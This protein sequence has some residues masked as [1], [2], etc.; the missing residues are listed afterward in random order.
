M[1]V[2]GENSLRVETELS[3]EMNLGPRS[4]DKRLLFF[5]GLP[6]HGRRHHG[7]TLGMSTHPDSLHSLLQQNARLEHL[8]RAGKLPG[9]LL[10]I[11]RDDQYLPDSTI[12]Q[13]THGPPQRTCID[14]PSG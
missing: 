10:E 8:W 12:A 2:P 14:E 11:T 4:I 6:E 13:S 7:V 5:Q 3:N 9:R 1:S